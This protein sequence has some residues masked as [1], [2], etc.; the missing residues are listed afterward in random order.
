MNAAW[1]RK[2]AG[3]TVAQCREKRLEVAQQGEGALTAQPEWGPIQAP[4]PGGARAGRAV[5]EKQHM[6]HATTLGNPTNTCQRSRIGKHNNMNLSA[7][8]NF[9]G[10]R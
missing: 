5:R 7:H 9:P 6:S 3:E 1:T 8:E 2:V 4:S 10:S